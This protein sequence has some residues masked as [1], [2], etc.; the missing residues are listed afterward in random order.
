MMKIR[1][2]IAAIVSLFDRKELNHREDY[3]DFASMVGPDDTF[4][5]VIEME[6]TSAPPNLPGVTN[7]KHSI[8]VIVDP[9]KV[10]KISVLRD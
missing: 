9:N 3:F 1:R 10:S 2:I 7:I 5:E 4:K 6:E 8:T